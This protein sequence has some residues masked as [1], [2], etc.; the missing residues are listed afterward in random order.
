[1]ERIKILMPSNFDNI[2]KIVDEISGRKKKMLITTAAA[3]VARGDILKA[4][5]ETINTM[6]AGDD[7]AIN[8]VD[9]KT[10][11]P[12]K[13]FSAGITPDWLVNMAAFLESAVFM[14]SIAQF[15]VWL[16]SLPKGDVLKN[17]DILTDTDLQWLYTQIYDITSV[18]PKK[19]SIE[20]CEQLTRL[21][22]LFSETIK[23]LKD[24]EIVIS[25]VV[26]DKLV[27]YAINLTELETAEMSDR[28]K[29]LF[30]K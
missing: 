18:K 24:N 16:Y 20:Y 19:A 12:E 17:V 11:D 23:E 2:V 25:D 29:A 22:A 28:I 14:T 3:F 8:A 13:R 5:K 10:L 21:S 9:L 4:T 15:I 1:M 27:F 30:D 7:V 26:E 6:L